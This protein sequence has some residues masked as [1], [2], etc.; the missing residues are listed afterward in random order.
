MAV[1]NDRPGAF[2]LGDV[3]LISYRSFDGSGSPKRLDIRN[4]IQEFY[5]L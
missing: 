1:V 2:E 5:N 4:L 3:I